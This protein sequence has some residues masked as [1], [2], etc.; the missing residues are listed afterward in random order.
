MRLFV[1]LEVPGEVRRQVDAAVE[2][3]RRRFPRLRWTRPDAWHLTLA[4]LGEVDAVV[5]DGLPDV[6]LPAVAET[7]GPMRLSLAGPDRFGRRVLWLGV[8]DEPPGAVALLGARVQQVAEA[9]GIEVD[10]RPVRAHLTLA[11]ARGRDP[12]GPA[13]VDACAPVAAS[14]TVDRA[15]LFRSELGGGP[16]R[17]EAPASLPLGT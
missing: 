14:W 11:R 3:L 7:G 10:R 12:V 17:Y 4:F 1:A 6:L 5:A 16:A 8:D 13:V 2:P 15:V 9:Q